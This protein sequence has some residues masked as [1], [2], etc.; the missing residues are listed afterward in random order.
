MSSLKFIFPIDGDF[1]NKYDGEIIDNTLYVDFLIET[2]CKEVSVCGKNADFDKKSGY[3][4][5]KVPLHG[6]RN[7]I[8]AKTENLD[9]ENRTL[10]AAYARNKERPL[11][12][13]W[14]CEGDIIHVYDPK[15]FLKKAE[16]TVETIDKNYNI[17]YKNLIGNIENDDVLSNSAY[18]ASVHV[19]GCTLK[20]TRAR[21]LL[22]QSQNV[23]IE[24]SYIYGMSLPAMLFSPDT[25]R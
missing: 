18:Y 11:P 5:V 4:K 10:F 1:V 25:L 15:T 17:C 22:I 6:Y 24:N 19:D 13:F 23:L 8:A 16:F 7:R 3:F 21:G 2:D 9:T 12:D 20:N 14:A